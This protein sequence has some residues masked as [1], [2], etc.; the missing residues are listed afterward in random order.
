MFS[1]K[2]PDIK[3]IVDDIH[4]ELGMTCVNCMHFSV[5]RS[6]Y[7]QGTCRRTGSRVLDTYWYC[8]AF[9]STLAG[10]GEVVVHDD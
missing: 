7:G 4:I 2:E 3:E 9:E 6:D 1:Y 10:A 8:H 5:D